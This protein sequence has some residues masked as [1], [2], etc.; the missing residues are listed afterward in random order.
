MSEIVE[1]IRRQLDSREE[2]RNRVLEASR[3]T[4]REASRAITALHRRDDETVEDAIKIAQ[5]GVKVLDD[6]VKANPWL[7]DY[8]AINSAY[9]EYAEI[10]LVKSLM[11]RANMPEPEEI[12]VPYKPY[13]G[14]LADTVGELRRHALDQIRN[15]D[16]EGAEKTLDKMEEIFGILSEFDYPDSILQGMRHKR[17][18]AR[19]TLEKTRGDVTTALRQRKLEQALKKTEESR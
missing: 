12:G 17:D 6:A 15:D 2:V 18:A 19:S 9:R 10:L 4:I 8:G 16:V 3:K 5:E 1:R 13:L 11:N 14:G 7:E